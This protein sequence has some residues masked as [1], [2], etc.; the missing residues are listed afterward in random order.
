MI[1]LLR[2][3]KKKSLLFLV[4]YTL[5]QL[6]RDRFVDIIDKQEDPPP[7]LINR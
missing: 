3:K 7:R 2:K 6:S 5:Q 1:V 4:F